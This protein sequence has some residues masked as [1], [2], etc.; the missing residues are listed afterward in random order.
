MNTSQK[1]R[2]LFI[3][4]P[5]AGL[6][7]AVVTLCFSSGRLPGDAASAALASGVF[8]AL[9]AVCLYWF[10]GLRSAW[11]SVAFIIVCMAALFASALAA[12]WAHHNLAVFQAF[13][14]QE[15]VIDPETFFVGGFVGAFLIVM[16]ALFLVFP[17]RSFLS[18]CF[19]ALGG[20]LLGGLL[21]LLGQ[22]G[23]GLVYRV[24]SQ[25]PVRVFCGSDFDVSLVVV[26]QTGVAF[27]LALILWM[28]A[29]AAF[30]RAVD[31]TQTGKSSS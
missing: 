3:A 25:L 19:K 28:E 23:G 14:T 7:S 2:W 16:A 6:L 10:F 15:S 20:G 24:R 18:T 11:K 12:G 8:G 22:A 31:G 1:R 30:K 27:I 9:N 5:V 21:G 29:N 26:W 4:F 17:V 13:R